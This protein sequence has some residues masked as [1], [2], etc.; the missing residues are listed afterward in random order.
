MRIT[1]K[2][3]VAVAVATLTLGLGVTAYAYWTTT[4]AGSG[5]AKVAAGNGTVVLDAA[6]DD[7]I[8]PGGEVPVTYTA[9]NPHDTDLHVGTVHAVVST[10]DGTACPASNFSIADLAANTVVPHGADGVALGTATLKMKN[11]PN[12]SQDGCKD[13]TVTLTLTSN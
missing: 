2:K 12:A 3:L 11:D 9:S 1:R 6:F 10:N 7:G 13:A 5:D 4:G 8:Y